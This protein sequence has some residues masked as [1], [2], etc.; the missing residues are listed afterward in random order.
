M[1][2]DDPMVLRGVRDTQL[3]ESLEL[4]SGGAYFAVDRDQNVVAF[5]PEMERIT[6]LRAP[7]VV[8]RHCLNAFRCSRCLQRCHVFE[9]GHVGPAEVEIYRSDG[10]P[11]RVIKTARA[12]RDDEGSV[13]LAIEHIRPVGEA[14]PA[15]PTAGAEQ[16][17]DGLLRVLGRVFLLVDED[18]RVR[19]AS[20][21]ICELLACDAAA[22]EGSPID[23]VVHD[24]LFEQG[25][26]L[27]TAL[28]AGER[29]EGL[30]ATLVA[31][32]GATLPVSL[33]ASRV[34][35]ATRS[36]LG[37][38]GGARELYLVL[39]RPEPSPSPLGTAGSEPFCGMVGRSPKMHALFRLITQLEGNDARVL[40]TGESGTGKELV[41]RAIHAH[42]S[43]VDGPF[44][45]LNC[46]ALPA[47]LLESELFGHVRG[48]FTGAIKDKAGRF[49][50][51]DGGT[52]FLDEVGDMP[53]ALQVKLLRVLEDGIFERIGD[54]RPRRADVRVISATNVDLAAAVG[55]KR[56][57]ED[58]YYRLRVVPIRVPALRE[59]REDI[60]LLTLHLLDRIGRRRGRA[61]RL[62][63]GVMRDLLAWRWPGNVRELENALEYATAVCDGQT[64]HRTDL[65]AEIPTADE[66]GFA[67]VTRDGDVTDSLRSSAQPTRIATDADSPGPANRASIAADS[68]EAAR[69]RAALEATH[70]KKQAA[71][72]LLGVSRWT[73]WRK[74]KEHGLA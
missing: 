29:R 33:S 65:P 53:L 63:P 2:G 15:R 1:S 62:S 40:I 7:D 6:G 10:T 60:E 73:L 30:R 36:L 69:I 23:T 11:L 52:L 31:A 3:L 9:H 59:R 5:S 41:A 21:G 22:L 17:L 67:A 46:G 35:A 24:D 54:P 16:A 28:L 58:L 20:A 49:E 37:P 70:Y 12:V 27:R 19:R 39:I 51:A 61:L 42:S 14:P 72:E 45:P 13:V 71:A 68:D 4:L 56:F 47:D 38:L 25:S 26:P 18:M 64:I 57:R 43:R 34:D 55:A 44:V 74:M 48:A 50:L 8:G 32:D 66:S